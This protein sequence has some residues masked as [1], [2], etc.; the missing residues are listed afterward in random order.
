M[1]SGVP[2]GRA[3]G[4]AARGRC[5]G[6][7]LGAEV[8]GAAAGVAPRGAQRAARASM[9]RAFPRPPKWLRGQGAGWRAW[10]RAST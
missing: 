6:P 1:A 10:W 7:P 2:R 8:G 4:V 9:A 3:A 5:G